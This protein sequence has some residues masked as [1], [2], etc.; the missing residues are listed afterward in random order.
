MKL[1]L[2]NN[3]EKDCQVYERKIIE[4]IIEIRKDKC[5]LFFQQHKGKDLNPY[6]K[7]NISKK[8][9]QSTRFFSKIEEGKIE[10][11]F[12]TFINLCNALNTNPSTILSEFV[13]TDIEN[14]S[15]NKLDE[16]TKRIIANFI[17]ILANDSN[18]NSQV[19]IMKKEYT[20]ELL[21]QEIH[22]YREK[23]GF[24]QRE[25]SEKLNVS[26]GYI[27]NV[28]NGNNDV[29][30]SSLI[31]ICNVLQCTPNDLLFPFINNKKTNKYDQLS[32]SNKHIVDTLINTLL[33]ETTIKSDIT[34][35]KLTEEYLEDLNRRI[36]RK[37]RNPF[38]SI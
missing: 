27:N 12:S 5:N 32:E 22:I 13:T 36:N 34:T 30:L 1:N 14:T 8:I 2:Q 18:Q 21:G 20:K 31:N 24:S 25:L 38:A 9:G 33:S 23:L 17:D 19:E 6:T 29:S 28:E 26:H 37:Y 16:N 11:N 15:W 35:Y 7:I 4:K 3:T 10:L